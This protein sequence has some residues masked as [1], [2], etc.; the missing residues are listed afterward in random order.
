[1]LDEQEIGMDEEHIKK[2]HRSFMSG[3]LGSKKGEI[4]P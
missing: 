4:E 1:M 3:V 2:I